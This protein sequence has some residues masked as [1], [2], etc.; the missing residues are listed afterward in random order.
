MQASPAP[1]KGSQ[2]ITGRSGAR[3]PDIPRTMSA[4]PE[5]DQQQKTQQ[6][7]KTLPPGNVW[8]NRPSIKS[9]LAQDASNSPLTSPTAANAPR[10]QPSQAQPATQAAAA[11]AQPAPAQQQQQQP[12]QPQAQAQAAPSADNTNKP[13]ANVTPNSQQSFAA[14]AAAAASNVARSAQ[15]QQQQHNSKRNNTHTTCTTATAPTATATASTTTCTTA[16]TTAS[17]PAAAAASTRTNVATRTSVNATADATTNATNGTPTCAPRQMAPGQMHMVPV[18]PQS[19]APAM[20][21]P[22]PYMHPH[23]RAGPHQKMQQ[24]PQMVMQVPPMA[25]SPGM[26]YAVPVMPHPMS[27]PYQRGPQKHNQAQASMS[28]RQMPAS[29]AMAMAMPP[30]AMIP[31]GWNQ[32][33]QYGYN[34]SYEQAQPMFYPTAAYHQQMA[35]PASYINQNPANAQQMRPPMPPGPPGATG[36]PRM[37]YATQPYVPPAKS[38]AIKIV[39]PSTGMVISDLNKANDNNNNNN[40][41]NNTVKPTGSPAPGSRAIPIVKPAEVLKAEEEAKRKEEEEAER[42]RK[43]EEEAERKRKEEE[44]EL[45]RK[46]EEE[47]ER[48]RKEEEEA[49][50]QT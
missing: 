44:A 45:K 2:A 37:P 41:N 6:P 38:Q 1:T 26:A 49:E 25:G 30:G 19:G 7:V 27:H 22:Q 18:H 39:D 12:Q 16:G 34:P 17:S 15:Q 29:P 11:Q 21:P 13:A 9:K 33:A 28:P 50:T 8:Q 14:A 42:K 46:A 48:K 5:L 43:E 47:A 36:S 40:S 3:V 4:P 10:G 20:T 35:Y 32:Y 24:Q 23:N 31:Q